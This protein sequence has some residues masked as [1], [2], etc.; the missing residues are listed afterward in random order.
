MMKASMAEPADSQNSF[1]HAVIALVAIAVLIIVFVD[2]DQNGGSHAVGTRDNQLAQVGAIRVPDATQTQPPAAGSESSPSP[3]SSD[4]ICTGTASDPAVC[5]SKYVTRYVEQDGGAP[6]ERFCQLSPNVVNTVC[7]RAVSAGQC[8]A[9]V[10][11]MVA[12]LTEARGGLGVEGVGSSCNDAYRGALTCFLL[13]DPQE[14]ASAHS[15]V[16]AVFLAQVAGASGTQWKCCKEDDAQC[17]NQSMTALQTGGGPD[18]T[19]TE[20]GYHGQ[21]QGVSTDTTAPP[22]TGGTSAGVTEGA[23]SAFSTSDPK[24]APAAG[25]QTQQTHARPSAPSET[26]FAGNGN[27]TAQPSTQS[28]GGRPSATSPPSAGSPNPVSP[29]PDGSYSHT[30]GA[31]V[32]DSSFSSAGGYDQPRFQS[33]QTPQERARDERARAAVD[34]IREPSVVERFARLIGRQ[35]PEGF[36]SRTSAERGGP[37]TAFIIRPEDAHVRNIRQIARDV[38]QDEIPAGSRVDHYARTLNVVGG[39]YSSGRRAT[40]TNAAFASLQDLIV[41]DE[42]I[43]AMFVAEQTATREK[44]K[45]FC[46]EAETSQ[47][48]AQ[49]R[50]QTEQRVERETFVEELEKR[51]LPVNA[52]EHF[53]AV[54]DGWVSPST[55]VP[56]SAPRMLSDVIGQDAPDHDTQT[57]KNPDEPGFVSWA[58]DGMRNSATRMLDTLRNWLSE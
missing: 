11:Q 54:Y 27:S 17:M 16:A 4:T 28:H 18:A 45:I 25:N 12:E 24:P 43:R 31:G 21:G 14:R 26:N 5:T 9:I 20:A 32:D 23:D 33:L 44:N 51:D 41:E 13:F 10:D 19:L 3:D 1:G 37:S 42:A 40:T 49:R 50:N 52:V 7:A 15:A 58:W 56:A 35:S 47:S 55:P 8:T 46:R 36:F 29:T 57:E 6:R 38:A 48:C 22:Q 53:L 30:S 2:F 34:A 39:P